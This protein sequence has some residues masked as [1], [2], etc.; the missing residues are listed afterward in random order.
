M[1]TKTLILATSFLLVGATPVLTPIDI[2][3]ATLAINY[4]PGIT[5]ADG[6]NIKCGLQ[7]GGPYTRITQVALATKQVPVSTIIG[8]NGSWFCVVTDYVQTA[9]GPLEGKGSNEI[10]FFAAVAPSGTIVISITP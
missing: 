7:T 8:A 4:T 3:R 10:N 2:N 5:P 6:L 9:S 1:K